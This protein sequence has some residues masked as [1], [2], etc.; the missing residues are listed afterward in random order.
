MFLGIIAL[1]ILVVVIISHVLINRKLKDYDLL[2]MNEKTEIMLMVKKTNANYSKVLDTFQRVV[3]NQNTLDDKMNAL[4]RLVD[5][6][7]T[8]VTYTQEQFD[9]LSKADVFS[10][11]REELFRT[12]ELKVALERLMG[13]ALTSRQPP[14]PN[15]VIALEN[16]DERISELESI[17]G[18]TKDYH[19]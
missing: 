17:L 18:K 3:N 11:R 16:L 10:A 19:E 4:A 5:E 8:S 6:H 1:L 15:D 13:V 12:K 14:A 9:A 7:S 2:V